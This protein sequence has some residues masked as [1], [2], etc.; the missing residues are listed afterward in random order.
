MTDLPVWSFLTSLCQL[1]LDELE[2]SNYSGVS[3]GR[4]TGTCASVNHLPS[5]LKKSIALLCVLEDYG[6]V[7][8]TKNTADLS[9][10]RKK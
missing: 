10:I 5:Y 2:D 1:L 3:R 8:D 7:T 9:C 6:S 4:N